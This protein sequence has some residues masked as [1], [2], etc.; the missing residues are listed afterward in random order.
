LKLEQDMY[1]CLL[2][3]QDDSTSL[4]WIRLSSVWT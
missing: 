3:V 1:P 4:C 2:G